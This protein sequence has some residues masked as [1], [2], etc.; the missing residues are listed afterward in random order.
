MAGAINCRSRS[1]GHVAL[2]NQRLAARRISV[3]MGAVSLQ[4][5]CAYAAVPG[6]HFLPIGRAT[7]TYAAGSAG[8]LRGETP[9]RAG[10][11]AAVPCLTGRR[12]RSG[13][14]H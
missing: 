14:P 12:F 8:G 4:G 7:Q 3:M 9:A 5:A 13:L 10:L 2:L 11:P 6:A 1:R